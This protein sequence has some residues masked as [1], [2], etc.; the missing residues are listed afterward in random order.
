MASSLA[1][2]G[3]VWTAAMD[4]SGTCSKR[5]PLE[6]Q[7]IEKP[8]P[9]RDPT[10]DQLSSFVS[11]VFS[12]RSESRLAQMLLLDVAMDTPCLYVVALYE[13]AS[14]N[15]YSDISRDRIAVAQKPMY[16]S[17]SE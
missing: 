2:T 6:L 13:S 7:R 10:C 9:G 16:T 17:L 8:G 5:L 11:C 12:L 4:L 3:M 15:A 1:G 14:L